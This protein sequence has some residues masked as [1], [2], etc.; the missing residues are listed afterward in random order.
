MRS[1]CQYGHS[2]EACVTYIFNICVI[3]VYLY[4]LENYTSVKAISISRYYSRYIET[5]A[6]A[7]SLKEHAHLLLLTPSVQTE[8]REL[9]VHWPAHTACRWL[10]S[11]DKQLWLVSFP[12]A[13]RYSVDKIMA[14]MEEN[15]FC[16]VF[17]YDKIQLHFSIFF[18]V[19][20][21]LCGTAEL[22][23][24]VQTLCLLI[25]ED[26][27]NFLTMIANQPQLQYIVFDLVSTC[28]RCPSRAEK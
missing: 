6:L 20:R 13:Y 28:E 12:W 8:M 10:W 15:S 26:V 18:L 3:H 17:F 4:S 14:K 19:V 7:G 22:S 11:N 5:I 1:I 24:L 23:A 21:R 9:S 2:G 25:N 16:Y 27:N